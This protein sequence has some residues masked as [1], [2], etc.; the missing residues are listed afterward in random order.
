MIDDSL[1]FYVIIFSVDNSTENPYRYSALLS[2]IFDWC[3][4]LKGL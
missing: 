1:L 2:N 4:H 3:G